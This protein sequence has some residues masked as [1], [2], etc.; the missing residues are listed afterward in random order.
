MTDCVEPYI[1]EV[2]TVCLKEPYEF[3]ESSDRSAQFRDYV[4]APGAYPLYAQISGE[5]VI[6][7]T[8]PATAVVYSCDNQQ[9]IGSS[10]IMRAPVFP[11]DVL[12]NRMELNFMQAYEYAFEISDQNPYGV[13]A[14]VG[15]PDEPVWKHLVDEAKRHYFTTDLFEYNDNLRSYVN[16]P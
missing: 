9:E 4:F 3:R 7:V 8:S 13:K 2:G 12:E 15:N 11:K 1:V 6:L 5:Q 10:K 14:F 16:N